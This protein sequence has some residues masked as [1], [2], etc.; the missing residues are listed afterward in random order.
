MAVNLQSDATSRIDEAARRR[1]EAAWRAG[2][3]EPLDNFLPA[4]D[5]SNYLTTLEELVHIE[6]ELAWKGHSNPKGPA[7]FPFPVEEYLS[8]FPNLKEPAILRRLV[9][10]EYQCR[11]R[12]G[13]G[14]ELAEYRARFPDLPLHD[15]ELEPTVA[16]PPK[17]PEVLPTIPG[18]EVLGILGKG[19]MGIVLKAKQISLGR[20][21]AIKQIV[22]GAAASDE[23]LARFKNEAAT[24][25]QL[26]HPNIVQIYEV[27]AAHG[28]P[29]LVLEFVEGGSLA[30]R[31]GGT[32]FPD[33]QAAELT[34]TLARAVFA[35]HQK[36][37]LHRDLKPHN[38]LLQFANA[39]MAANQFSAPDSPSAIYNLKSAI[40]KITDFGLAKDLERRTE[41]HGPSLTETGVVV[42][43]PSYMAP[44]Q[45]AGRTKEIGPPADIYAL[46]TILYEMLTGRPPFRGATAMETIGQVLSEEAI[47]PRRLRRELPRDLET[48][49]MKCLQKEPHRRY[50][51]ALELAEDI[52]RFLAGDPIRARPVS[53]FERAWRW[54]RRK[55]ALAGVTAA[56]CV[57]AVSAVVV[58]F[59]WLRADDDRRRQALEFSLTKKQAVLRERETRRNRA[60][61]QQSLAL[62][63]LRVGR[64]ESALKFL[65]E[66]WDAVQ[67]EPELRALQA[68]VANQHD[69]VKRLVDFY[70]LS[71]RAE[72]RAFLEEDDSALQICETALRKL[73]VLESAT[74]WWKRL[75]VDDLSQT[76]RDKLIRDANHQLILLAGLYVKD[77]IMVISPKPGQ[78]ATKKALETL[79]Y[80]RSY[81]Q[82]RKLE[83]PLAG[84]FLELFARHG[85]AGGRKGKPLAGKEPVTASDCYFLG[86]AYFWAGQLPDHILSRMINGML[87]GMGLDASDNKRS[88]QRLLRRAA[89][90]EPGHYWSHFWLGWLLKAHKDYHGAELAF[91]NCVTVRPDYGLGYAERAQALILQSQEAD[92]VAP[93]AVLERRGRADMEKALA[94]DPH[95][96]QVQVL[97]LDLAWKLNSADEFR[98]ALIQ[99]L[100]LMPP[101]TLVSKGQRY[102]HVHILKSLEKG[103]EP[104]RQQNPADA[105]VL[106]FLALI[107]HGLEQSGT[108][109]GEAE[110]TLELAK[111][112]PQLDD[113]RRRA[114]LVRG[115]AALNKKDAPKALADFQSVLDND[116]TNYHATRGQGLAYEIMQNW[117]KAKHCY[118]SL[119]R[120]AVVDW[121]RLEALLGLARVCQATGK[122]DEAEHALARA[123]ELHPNAGSLLRLPRKY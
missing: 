70:S 118:D 36:G 62:G 47:S 39:D 114:L 87:A 22:A 56:L 82:A 99:V 63:E 121:Q 48:I 110:K 123:A 12:A 59:F 38:V 2:K 7:V 77:S 72:R 68:A 108:A 18:Y 20:I 89:A 44:E 25:A 32:P 24:V 67:D 41:T 109:L 19:G 30:D 65:R 23:D 117:E 29:F 34:A 90:E 1:F 84:Q 58:F 5:A 98:A 8:R 96:F 6:I 9:R 21:V 107:H 31:L 106:S 28:R 40:P 46:G 33:R 3:P 112:D 15:E 16:P 102:E 26:Q 51:T 93:R 13:A 120:L 92:P 49:C 104:S 11:L 66:A 94:L 35:V 57:A 50:G 101:G 91:N 4:K 95:D 14:P 97:R 115:F 119:L 75:P 10:Q 111:S 27:G 103:L 74:E 43:T 100:D 42:G 61:T 113:C 71:E 45:A 78:S 86:I 88:A 80:V 83:A 73:G 122:V 17:P 53:H 54:C 116:S 79:E 81:H 69:R 52:D 55:P 105:R 37:I 76:Q 64:F 60:E 85:I